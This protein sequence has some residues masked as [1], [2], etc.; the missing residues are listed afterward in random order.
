[1]KWVLFLTISGIIGAGLA[2]LEIPIPV[3]TQPRVEGG[4]RPGVAQAPR[5]PRRIFASGFVEGAQREV[6]LNFEIEGRLVSL[7]VSEGD[8]VKAGD[9]LARLD[10]SLLEHEV[11]Q[12]SAR[13]ALAQAERERVANAARE[14]TRKIAWAEVAV[15][16]VKLERARAEL[17]RGEQ[18]LGKK[19][20]AQKDWDDLQHDFK[21]ATADLQ[22]AKAKAAEADAAA[23]QDDLKISDANVELARSVL[24]QAQ[25]ML[26][27]ATLVAPSS[28]LI[29]RISVE[30]GQLVGPA[31][32]TPVITMTNVDRLRVRA[33]VEELD[34][35]D[36]RPG[37]AAEVTADGSPEVYA[38][39]VLSCVPHMGQKV[40]RDHRPG[41]RL[42]V[43][44]RE[45]IVALE[46][47][48]DLLVGLPVEVF[49]TPPDDAVADKEVES[50]KN[51]GKR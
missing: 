7:L 8:R 40:F 25:T 21:S 27:K 5:T 9:V 36:V 39:T 34:A 33:Y 31:H 35:L 32:A 29:L 2:V 23:R 44:V 38:G 6:P 46:N 15:A 45:I 41:E 3:G 20:I 30:P 14:E 12:A 1:M 4:T 28:G 22:L 16:E 19:A 43:R 26:E 51:H 11:A 13:L 42:D 48:P 49:I 24:R 47:A 17:Q 10:A 37:Q 18:L 50:E